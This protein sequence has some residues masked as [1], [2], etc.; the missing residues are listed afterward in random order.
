ML[1]GTCG[2]EDQHPCPSTWVPLHSFLLLLW[3][4]EL[5]G[6]KVGYKSSRSFCRNM[7]L[8]SSFI[9]LGPGARTHLH[10]SFHIPPSACQTL[11]LWPPSSQVHGKDPT[12]AFAFLPLLESV[13]VVHDTSVPTLPPSTSAK[14]MKNVMVESCTLI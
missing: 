8:S 6:W 13:K 1:G 9:S 11:T 2:E 14:R 5:E 12:S 7:S 10:E 3:N 4:L